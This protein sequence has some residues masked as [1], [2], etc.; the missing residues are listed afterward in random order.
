MTKKI[1]AVG[2]LHFGISPNNSLKFDTMFESQKRFV[3]EVLIPTLIKENIKIVL[4]MGDVYDQRRRVDSSISQFVE[5]MFEVL[6]ADFECII[7]QGNHD[8]YLKDELTISSLSNIWSK[9]NV[10]VHQKIESREIYGKNFLFVPWLTPKLEETFVRNAPK[11]AGKFDYVVGHFETIGFPFEGGDVCTVGLDADVLI[12]NFKHTISG[13]FHTQTYRKVGDGSIHYIGTPYQLTFADSGEVKGFHIIDLDTDER[14]F[15]RNDASSEFYKISYTELDVENLSHLRNAFV[16]M[17]YPE[18]TPEAELFI[19]E[20]K[21]REQSPVS[22]KSYAYLPDRIQDM[23]GTD[24]E[25]EVKIF[26]DMTVAITSEDMSSMTKV[27]LEAKPYEDPEMV[28][29]MIEE[30]RARI[31]G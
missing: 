1:A 18:G 26:E 5:Y 24:S 16:E 9:K 3:T 22:F 6:L 25:A 10:K 27:F 23:L 21:I 14:T 29:E 30:I 11:F 8:T 4:F 12:K 20:T 19:V 15:I 7:V 17:K 13:H 2:D 28:L 31:S